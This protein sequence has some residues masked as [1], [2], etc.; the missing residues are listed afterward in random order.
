[1]GSNSVVFLNK[2]RWIALCVAV[3]FLMA[4]LAIGSGKR[5]VDNAF[6]GIHGQVVHDP[7]IDYSVRNELVK[8][9]AIE[10]IEEL[11]QKRG[12]LPINQKQLEELLGAKLPGIWLMGRDEPL[13]YV[14]VSPSRYYLTYSS[15]VDDNWIYDSET[16]SHGWFQ[17]WD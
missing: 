13:R 1:M 3:I 15:V 9:T 12:Q 4:A 8:S 16:S 7:V 10:Q 5:L 14:W 11:R 6:N 17:V 2:K